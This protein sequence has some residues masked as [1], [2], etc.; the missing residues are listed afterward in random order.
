MSQLS[1]RAKLRLRL[2]AGMLRTEGH[3]FKDKEIDFYDQVL[4][5]LNS[6]STE[7]QARWKELIDWVEAY[8]TGAVG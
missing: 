7:E 2:G 5:L 1:E 4:A 8:E 3:S 6:F